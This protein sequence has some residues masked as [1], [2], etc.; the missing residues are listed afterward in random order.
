MVIA[1]PNHRH[2][3]R[4]PAEGIGLVHE[5]GGQDALQGITSLI[6]DGGEKRMVLR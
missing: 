3:R 5:T 6:A 1:A 2:I 4:H